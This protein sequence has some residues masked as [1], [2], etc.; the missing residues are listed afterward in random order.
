M[1]GKVI[2]ILLLIAATGIA[3]ADSFSADYVQ[4][5][6]ELQQTDGW[7]SVAIGDTIPSDGTIRLGANAYAEIS[8]GS[9]TVKLSSP[10]VYHMTSLVQGSAAASSAGL[11]SLLTQRVEA[12]VKSSDNQ[13][14]AVVGGVRAAEAQSGPQTVWAGGGNTEQ[15][16]SQGLTLMQQGKYNEAFY[17][18]K[19]AYD[20]AS[21]GSAPKASFYMGY[22]ASLRNDTFNAIKYLATYKPDPSTGYYN[23]QVLTLGQLYVQTF[24]YKNA[25]ALLDPYIAANTTPSQALQTAYLLDGLAYQGLGDSAK[26]TAALTKARDLVPGSAIS[27]S[28]AKLLSGM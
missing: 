4:G 27:S 5:T 6:V 8:N 7:Y 24:A 25:V 28:A 1:K 2:A 18:F 17:T 9:V 13:N 23:D 20:N 16:I 26:A 10:G 3:A 15:L 11:A 12:L 21:S 19:D 22:A 14:S